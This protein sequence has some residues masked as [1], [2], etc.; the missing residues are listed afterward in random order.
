LTASR[1]KI[2]AGQIRKKQPGDWLSAAGND[3]SGSDWRCARRKMV[4]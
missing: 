1:Q 3:E 4:A 2:D